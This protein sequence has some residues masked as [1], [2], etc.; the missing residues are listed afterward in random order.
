MNVEKATRIALWGGLAIF[1]CGGLLLVMAV[2]LL[3]AEPGI[4]IRAPLHIRLTA[5]AGTTFM[6]TGVVM[7]IIGAVLK[8]AAPNQRTSP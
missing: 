6:G 1:L 4:A 2:M 3:A 5:I 7:A 8:I